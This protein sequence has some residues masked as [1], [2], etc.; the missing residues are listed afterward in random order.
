MAGDVGILVRMGDPVIIAIV[1]AAGVVILLSVVGRLW[2]RGREAAAEARR[3]AA[4]REEQG[5]LQK[6]Q[7]EVE[8]LAG[9]IIATSSTGSITGF[10]I[11]RQVEAVFTDGHA[12]PRKAVERLKARAAEKGANALINLNSARPP[13]GKCLAHGDA[14][15][16]RPV[17]EKPA[18]AQTESLPPLPPMPPGT[19]ESG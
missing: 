4:R 8:R 2:R 14:V 13:S 5:Y 1:L 7:A 3:R 6:Q 17:E 15:I 19:D 16:V 10:E 18:E 11:V 9:K 12:T